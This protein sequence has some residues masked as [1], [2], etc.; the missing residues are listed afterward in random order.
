MT[1]SDGP[2]AAGVFRLCRALCRVV[3]PGLPL[4][5]LAL[6][7]TPAQAA[8]DPAGASQA[9]ALH[10]LNRLAFGPAP[11]DLAHVE[12]IGVQAYIE[13]QLHPERLP[14]PPGLAR[15]LAALQTLEM[16]PSALIAD[17]GPPPPGPDGKRDIAALKAQR[18][19][20]RIILDQAVAARLLRA[21][22]SPRQLQEVMVDFWYNH[23]N[24]YAHKGLDDL[25]I[26]AYE[27]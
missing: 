13:E 8:G 9:Q 5:A 27:A 12:K 26:G 3:I 24:V 16:T 17:Y 19:R 7:V 4:L 18:Q 14:L 2:F 22:E 11:G 15:R 1:R 23:F 25:W 6:P 20:S 21:V 10:V